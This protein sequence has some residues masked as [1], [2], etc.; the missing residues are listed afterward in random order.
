MNPWPFLLINWSAIIIGNIALIVLFKKSKSVES[1]VIFQTSG[2][3]LLITDLFFAHLAYDWIY[4]NESYEHT[5]GLGLELVIG[6]ITF[7]SII[8]LGFLG[9]IE[10]KNQPRNLLTFTSLMCLT[11]IFF[12]FF[13][14]IIAV[15][16]ILIIFW[17]P[18]NKV[19]KD[20]MHQS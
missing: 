18:Y 1:K 15:M 10:V 12:P 19:A 2:L 13:L 11:A 3:L 5:I 20:Q 4:P 14:F 9:L 16:P 6:F 17:R 7:F 8:V